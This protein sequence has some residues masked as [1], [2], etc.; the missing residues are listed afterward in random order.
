MSII[1][2]DGLPVWDDTDKRKQKYLKKPFLIDILSTKNLTQSD[3]GSNT[4]LCD[5]R[6]ATLMREIHLNIILR[7]NPHRSENTLHL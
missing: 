1:L 6:P 2:F 3:P 7:S 5:E 4:G